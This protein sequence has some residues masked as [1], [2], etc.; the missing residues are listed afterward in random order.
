MVLSRGAV[1]FIIERVRTNSILLPN[2]N[3]PNSKKDKI[4]G[5]LMCI[6]AGFFFGVN[7]NPV[8]NVIDT[9]PDADK[10]VLSYVFW[11]FLGI[12]SASSVYFLIY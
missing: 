11:H 6:V 1:F 10:R 9:Q 12:W 4:V 8:F 5:F 3:R 7:F 2:A